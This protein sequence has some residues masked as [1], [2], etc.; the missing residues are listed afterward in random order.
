MRFA[1]Y[2]LGLGA[3]VGG[4]A[5]DTA[6]CDDTKALTELAVNVVGV[7][8]EATVG[9]YFGQDPV[10]EAP[11]SGMTLTLPLPEAP[12]EAAREVRLPIALAAPDGTFVGAA[13]EWL[14]WSEGPGDPDDPFTLL[15]G[16]NLLASQMTQGSARVDDCTATAE[17]DLVPADA[18]TLQG[19][20]AAAQVAGH[21]LALVSSVAYAG[22]AVASAVVA[23]IPAADAWSLTADAPPPDDH[24]AD[25]TEEF[26]D[27]SRVEA[28]VAWEALVL[29]ADTDGSGGW[30]PGDTD[31]RLACARSASSSEALRVGAVWV[32]PARS[33]GD[34]DTLGRLGLGA[35]WTATLGTARADR[36]TAGAVTFDARC[37]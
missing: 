10:V 12:A 23:D 24:L 18:V 31:V 30:S 27:S 9:V 8:G 4:T 5:P 21:H 19:T 17:A 22:G 1:L 16:W 28:T 26:D 35:G 32:P 6:P 14:T 3:C 15:H 7:P 33:P 29:Y 11:V 37:E 36:A 20:L 2:A 34:A 13:A 25:Y